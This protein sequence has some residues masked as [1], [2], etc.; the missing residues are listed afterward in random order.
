MSSKHTMRLLLLQILPQNPFMNGQNGCP[1]LL[2][3]LV[4]WLRVLALIN[5]HAARL[6]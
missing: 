4:G 2:G 5:I 1:Q 6:R 3:W